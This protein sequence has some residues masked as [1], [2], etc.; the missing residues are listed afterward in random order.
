LRPDEALRALFEK[1]PQ[2]AALPCYADEG[3]DIDALIGEVLGSRKLRITA[4]ARDLLAGRLGADRALSRGEI[5]KLALYAQG[6]A[7]VDEDDVEAIV[8]DASALDLDKAVIAAASGN[9]GAALAACD[10]VIAA[11]E[12]AQGLIA[13]TQRYFMRLHRA[14]AEI[15]AGRSLDE[16]LRG[17]RPPMPFKQKSAFSAQLRHW[18]LARLNRAVAG[19]GRAAKAARLSPLEEALASRLLADLAKLGRR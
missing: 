12:S 13:A 16:V 11:G 19:I 18:D 17:V 3:Q 2:A 1:S 15:E 4:D 8:G 7:E 6:K 10:R 5:E 9:A 14:R